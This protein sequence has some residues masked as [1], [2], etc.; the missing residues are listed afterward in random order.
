MP[1]KIN[2]NFRSKNTPGA[3]VGYSNFHHNIRRNEQAKSALPKKELDVN[4]VDTIENRLNALDVQ[5]K[6]SAKKKVPE[7]EWLNLFHEVCTTFRSA[8]AEERVDIQIAFED[9]H[10]LLDLFTQYLARMAQNA[11]QSAQQ[12]KTDKTI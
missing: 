12:G 2:T 10:A 5:L 1:E 8:T 3:L 9:R 7:K 6:P 4:S 11:A